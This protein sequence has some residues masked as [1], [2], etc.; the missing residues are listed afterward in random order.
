[1][2]MF[3]VLVVIRGGSPTKWFLCAHCYCLTFIVA[4]VVFVVVVVEY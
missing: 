4:V 3:T 2:V 1:M